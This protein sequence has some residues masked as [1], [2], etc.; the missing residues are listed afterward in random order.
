[1]VLGNDD[2][3]TVGELL[4]ASRSFPLLCRREECGPDCKYQE[5][6]TKMP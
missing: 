5:P 2:H 1:M 6:G 3:E 4:H